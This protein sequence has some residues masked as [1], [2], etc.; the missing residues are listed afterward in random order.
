MKKNQ[1][2]SRLSKKQIEKILKENN[3]VNLLWHFDMFAENFTETHWQTLSGISKEER[4][5]LEKIIKKERRTLKNHQEKTRA[6]V[7][8]LPLYVFTPNTGGD[9]HKLEDELKKALTEYQQKEQALVNQYIKEQENYAVLYLQQRL[10]D[11]LLHRLEYT[12]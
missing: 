6:L 5:N 12:Q 9:I 3:N 2:N 11:T 1:N 7:E 4:K 10:N 8:Q